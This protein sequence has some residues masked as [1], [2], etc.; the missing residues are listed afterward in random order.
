VRRLKGPGR[1]ITSLEDRIEVLA[2]LSSVDHIV[3]FADD[4]PVELI[5]KIRPDV[6]V[7][8]GDYTLAMLPEAPVVKEL[9]G[10]VRI[11]PYVDDRSTSAIID[12][13]RA[14]D[15]GTEAVPRS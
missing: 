11:L 13:V 1:P 2:A 9:G 10:V 14:H 3:S 4:T 7:K 5:G 6:F 8:G 12:R 15:A